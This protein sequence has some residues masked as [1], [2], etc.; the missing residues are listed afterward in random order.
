MAFFEDTNAIIVGGS[1]YQFIQAA[2]NAA[3]TSPAKW[4]LIP[5]T[6]AN[7]DTYTNASNV[8]VLDLRPVATSTGLNIPKVVSN[9]VRAVSASVSSAVTAAAGGVFA[10]TG[11]TQTTMLVPGNSVFE[12]VPFTVKAGGFITLPIGTYTCTLQPLLYASTTTNFTAAASNAIYSAAAAGCTITSAVAISVP[13]EIEAHLVGDT[14]SGKVNGWNQGL[15]P[16]TGATLATSVISPTIISN[17]LS[18]VTL[19]AAASGLAF[20]MGYTIAGTAGAYSI[21]LGSFYVSQ[22]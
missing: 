22:G 3:A 4:V 6:Y 12:Q 14:V 18:S 16:V 13:W 2:V 21:N 15:L 8:T 7:T 1:P 5:S 11:G 20:A 9:N 10:N 19:T 17:A